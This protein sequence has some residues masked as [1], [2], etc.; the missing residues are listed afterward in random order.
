VHITV[1]G[2]AL[3][4]SSLSKAKNVTVEYHW[5]EGQYAR[6]PAPLADLVRRR[7]TVIG[8]GTSP[9]ALAAKAATTTPVSS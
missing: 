8:A 9:V 7:V 6:L 2:R 4:A 1:V 3:S 5:G